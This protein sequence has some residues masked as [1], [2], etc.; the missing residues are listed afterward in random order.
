MGFIVLLLTI[1]NYYY[2]D[3]SNKL[4]EI[5]FAFILFLIAYNRKRKGYDSLLLTISQILCSI[6]IIIY[7]ATQIISIFKYIFQ[8]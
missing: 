3:K 4:L 1:L 8:L 2:F 7:L 6:I 5:L